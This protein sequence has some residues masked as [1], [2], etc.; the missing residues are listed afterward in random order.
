MAKVLLVE[1]DNNLREIYQARLT[2]EGYDIVAAQ[3]GEEALVVAKQNKPDLIISDVMMP[4]ISGFEMLDILRNTEQLKH[5]KVIMLTALGQ[6]EDQKRADTLGADKYLVKSQ[7]TLEDI[8]NAAKELLGETTGDTPVQQPAEPTP[9]TPVAA[10]A[11]AVQTPTPTAAPDSTPVPAPMT[12][13]PAPAVAPAPTI[14]APVPEPAQA[15]VPTAVP[16]PVVSEPEAPAPVPASQSTAIPA[17]VAP[18]TAASAPTPDM[19]ASV[20]A[21][22]PTAPTPTVVPTA[23]APAAPVVTPPPADVVTPT[24][25]AAPA[26]EPVAQAPVPAVTPTPTQDA[27]QTLEAEEAAMQAQ[28]SNY[29]QT[30]AEPAIAVEPSVTPEMLAPMQDANIAASN[31][32]ANDAAIAQAVQALNTP[33]PAPIST[34]PAAPVVTPPPADVVTPTVEAAPAPEPA[35]AVQ[36]AT[37]VTSVAPNAPVTPGSTQAE[38]ITPTQTVPTPPPV[39]A[40]GVTGKKIIQ[41]LGNSEAKPSLDELLAKEES[42]AVTAT[43]IVGNTPTPPTP[44][45]HAPGE[46][47]DPNVAL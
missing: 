5:T 29:A 26:P 37:P 14:P 35:Q 9:A 27:A 22:T 39:P 15:V 34:T 21:V 6:A 4:R 24:V 38:V 13:T 17:P 12:T 30:P 31:E 11:P 20:P 25:E 44:A 8:V 3:N 23:E 42:K 16:A 46:S 33:Q 10:P 40:G 18:V 47:F 36:P 43:P 1:D 28:I 7:V 2:A 19:Q 32:A 45:A 41:P